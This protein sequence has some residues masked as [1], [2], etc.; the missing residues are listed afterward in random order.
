MT[1]EEHSCLLENQSGLVAP[2]SLDEGEVLEGL[3]YR[4]VDL[5]LGVTEEAPADLARLG[6]VQP[7]PRR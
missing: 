4:A 5:D 3:E 6:Q 1:L 2:A 7:P